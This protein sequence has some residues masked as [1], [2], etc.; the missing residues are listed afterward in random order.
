M[1]K[2]TTIKF[3]KLIVKLGDG[4]T[5]EVFS[6]PCGF[7]SKAFTRSKTL[8]EVVVPDCDDPDA[9]ANVERD[10]ASLSWAVTGNGVLAGESLEAW[11]AFYD[12]TDPVNVIIE[13]IF[14]APIGT[15][16]YTGAAHLETWEHTAELGQR[17]NA[18]VSIQGTGALVR[19][20][21]LP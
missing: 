1:T 13:E 20:P 18:S 17:V 12:S 3:G 19:S 6:A 21:A 11:D 8:N 16:T 4:E 7:T 14:D 10:V 9:P 15:I 5:P 2:P